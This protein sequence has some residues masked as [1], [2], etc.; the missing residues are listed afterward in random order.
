MSDGAD[1]ITSVSHS[2][3]F[4]ECHTFSLYI[5]TELIFFYGDCRLDCEV[6]LPSEQTESGLWWS[7][8][9]LESLSS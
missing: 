3:A 9:K 1:D 6:E 5:R 7:A 8:G 2:V 4:G